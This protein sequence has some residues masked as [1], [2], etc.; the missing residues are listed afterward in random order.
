VKEGHVAGKFKAVTL[1]LF[2]ETFDL[3]K[4]ILAKAEA[5]LTSVKAGG[6]DELIPQLKD[7]DA[8]LTGRT[9][10]SAKVI[11]ALQAC[12]IIVRYGIGVD[13][14]DVAA[15]ARRNILVSNVPDY[16]IEEVSTHTVALLLCAARKIV[17]SDKT[18]RTGKWG[19]QTLSPLRRLSRQTLGIFGFGRIGRMVGEK[20][21]PLGMRIIV[22]DPYL[23]ADTVDQSKFDLVDFATLLRESD[24]LTIHSPLTQETKNRFGEAEF[25]RMKPSV[26]LINAARGEIVDEQALC[27]A[28]SEGW[29]GGAAL[30]ALVKEPPDP[31]SP[32]WK[33]DNVLMTPHSAWYSEEAFVELHT[34]AAEEAARV[35][36][37]EPPMYPVQAQM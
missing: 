32:L 8:I 27:R 3:E 33:L 26:I 16:C 31:Q 24:Y 21:H 12:R 36:R 1:T 19:V 7:A 28:L 11:D 5:D 20:T 30:D 10:I 17:H 9:K 37:G 22:S 34:K 14:I 29:I 4:E 6:E 2:K 35:L 23:T 18:V 15:A 13:N 25:R